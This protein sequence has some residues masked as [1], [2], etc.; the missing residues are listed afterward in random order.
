MFTMMGTKLLYIETYGCQMNEYDSDRI[1]NALDAEPT[2]DPKSADIIIINTCAIREKADHKAFSSLGKFKSLKAN[3]PDKIVGIAG[4]VAQL[5]GDKLL[6]KMPHID[7]VIGPRAIP[8]LPDIIS[9]IE[10]EKRR[11]VETSYDIEELFEIEPYHREGKVTA[12][13]SVQQGCNKR[14][15]YCIVPHVRGNEVN[16]PLKDILRETTNLVNKGVREITFIGQTVNSWKENGNKFG[17]LI[18]AAGDVENLERIRFTTSYPRDITKRMIDAMK[19]VPQVCHHLHLPVQSGSDKVLSRMKRTY[20]RRWYTDTISRLKDA[21]PD[22]T[23][24][25]D[26]IIGFPG[27]TSQDFEET[28]SL[29]KEVEFES[30]YSFKFS[31]RPGTPAAEYE[32]EEMVEPSIASARLSELQAFQKDITSRKNLSRVGH[33]EEVLVEGESRNDPNFI[34][35]RTDHNR[36][37]NFKGTK[38]LLGKTVKVKVTE[39]LLNSL[40]GELVV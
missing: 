17:D 9:K 34:S 19:D 8:K 30:A 37:L 27:E 23:V 4:C 24:S 14:C 21:V 22:L 6:K 16:R 10:R 15:T 5:Y 39:G 31:P 1:K 13:V 29:M 20:T 40:R 2:D 25:T 18:R 35:G 26:I 36:I 3:N 38:D 32:G 33:V 12:Y 7:F 11:T 28:M